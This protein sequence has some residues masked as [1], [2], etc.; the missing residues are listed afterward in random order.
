M[1]TI[2]IFLFLVAILICNKTLNSSYFFKQIGSGIVI[3]TI[4]KLTHQYLKSKCNESDN[5]A[6]K[7][8][9]ALFIALTC[10]KFSYDI[11]ESKTIGQAAKACISM[12]LTVSSGLMTSLILS[13]NVQDFF[14]E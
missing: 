1:K 2:K 3:G 8:T 11:L 13:Y 12:P 14:Q 5:K 7:K 4:S 10:L 6:L 9:I